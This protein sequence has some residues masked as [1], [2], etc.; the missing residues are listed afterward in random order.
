MS[1]EGNGNPLQFLPGESSW[2]RSLEGYSSQ[3]R[4]VKHDWSTKH[5]TQHPWL[6][7]SREPYMCSSPMYPQA[8]L[9]SP[10]Y[11]RGHQGTETLHNLPQGSAGM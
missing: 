1:G 3:G 8:L 7:L 4:R 9:L 11:R 5:S 6:A 2:M 10:F